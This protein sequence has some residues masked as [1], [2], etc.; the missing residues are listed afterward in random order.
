MKKPADTAARA[1]NQA[2]DGLSDAV[3]YLR[4][5]PVPP[6]WRELRTYGLDKFRAD[7]T[8]A[9]MVAIVT[10]PQAIG[11]ALVV[12]I[13]AGAVIATAVIGAFVCAL[14]SSSRHL[15]FGPTNTIAIILAGALLTV[16]DVPL[17]ALQKVLVIGFLMGI[18][19]VSAGFFKLGAL[20]HFI[21]RTVIVAYSTAVA[22]L[23]GVGQMGN[24]FGL[25]T[26]ADVSLPGTLKHII[27]SLG[28]F[29]LNPMTAGIGVAS[30]LG[31]LLIRRL[32]PSWPDGLIVIGVA[33]AVGFFY[34]YSDFGVQLVRDGG[35]V[36]GTMPLFVGFPSN[37]EG[38]S[39]VPAL[40]SVALA[41][42]ILGMLEA[43]SITKTLAA[44]SGQRVNPNQELLAMGLGNLAA[45]AFGAMPGSSSFVRSA[46]CQQSGGATQIASM[47]ASVI[48]LGALAL[49]AGLINYIPIA[50]LA[51]YLV[52]VSVR[53]VQ[54]EQIRVV[55]RATRSDAIVFVVTL[56][57]ALFLKLDTAVYVGIGVSLVLFLKKASAPS[58]VEYGFNAEGQ[59]TTLDEP[60]ART[61]SAISIVHVEGELFFGAADLF[62]DQVR[63]LAEDSNLRVVI[64]RMKNARHLDATSVMSLLQLHDS[65]T[66]NGRHLI[67][68]GINP[69][70]HR[71]LWRSGAWKTIGGDNIFPAEANLTMS[72]KKALQRAKKLLAAEGSAAKAE[73]RIFYDRTRADAAPATQTGP[74]VAGDHDKP[75][76][77]QI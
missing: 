16:K 13:P 27:Y 1:F 70:I 67:I 17:T 19:Q 74:A 30:L 5:D 53:L 21:S 29:T 6:V 64:L 23:I 14:F 3:D 66:K 56:G 31:M 61:N 76:D 38:I 59:L 55:F 7:L 41:A 20:T 43:V 47:V 63:Y 32:R 69:D 54:P 9:A 51:A 26:S 42:A 58:L 68:S 12:G 57:S 71:V 25:G 36:A 10:I 8:A 49:V 18:F 60:A 2:V 62:Q 24:L 34:H 48:V 75:A 40:T 39:L 28:T 33:T 44:R 4:L 15:V 11:F 65:L 72:T 45:T 77:Y 52:L 35:A 46:V 73:V 22:V 37:A 50:T